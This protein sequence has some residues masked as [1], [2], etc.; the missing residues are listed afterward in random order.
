MN[1]FI[2]VAEA[3]QVPL[4]RGLMVQAG[5][6]QLAL[7]NENGAFYALDNECPHRG[8]ALGAGF[9]E[10]GHVYCP[11]HGWEFEF[12]TGRCIDYPEH[13]VRCYPCRLQD[14]QVQVQLPT[15]S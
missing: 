5:S 8:G 6:R 13:A 12:K 2:T 14:G 3:S 9:T 15:S 7:F 1:D 4:D 10:N 11:M